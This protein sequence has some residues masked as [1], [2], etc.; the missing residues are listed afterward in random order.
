[1]KRLT[2]FMQHIV[3]NI[4]DIV[5]RP[6]ANFAQAFGQPGRRWSNPDSTN[7]PRGITGTQILVADLD[8]RKIGRASIDC[9]DFGLWTLDFG[10][11]NNGDFASNPN[12][13][14]TVR[15]VRRHLDIDHEV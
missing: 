6:L 11:F 8:G 12:M 14:E 7:N 13:R 1:M 15:P 4:S 5:D 3:G 2:K 10:L 9:E